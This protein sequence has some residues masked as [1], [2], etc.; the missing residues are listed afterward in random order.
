M[1]GISGCDILVCQNEGCHDRGGLLPLAI[2][3]RC[4]GG[5]YATDVTDA[6]FAPSSRRRRRPSAAGGGG[7]AVAR[8]A[9][10]A[11]V[12][13][14]HRLPMAH[15]AAEFPPRARC[16]AIPPLWQDGIWSTI[17]ATCS[18]GSGRSR[19]ASPTAGII[20]SQSVRTTKPAARAASMP[21]RRSAAGAAPVHRHAGPA[22]AAGRASGRPSGPDGLGLVCAGS[23]A[24]PLAAAPVR[25]C[26]LSGRDRLGCCSA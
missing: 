23:T 7:H 18:W 22:A 1:S 25:R 13:A 26:R 16:T 5:R 24:F 21:A 3:Y 2:E 15:A 14:P 11:A 9:E 10:R 6:E 4:T 8:G 17:K 20:D 12:S 19:E